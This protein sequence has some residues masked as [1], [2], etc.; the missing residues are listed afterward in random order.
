MGTTCR[1]CSVGTYT[2]LS[3]SIIWKFVY[4]LINFTFFILLLHR[5]IQID[6]LFENVPVIFVR[7]SAVWAL[8]QYTKIICLQHTYKRVKHYQKCQVPTH[9]I[10]QGAH[11]R[12]IQFF[13]EATD[14]T[15][16]KAS[17]KSRRPEICIWKCNRYPNIYINIIFYTMY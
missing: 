4:Y 8:H 3:V 12:K 16:L 15:L 14:V 13:I 17:R 11:T 6:I 10:E 5:R 7:L 1:I 9:I 2:I